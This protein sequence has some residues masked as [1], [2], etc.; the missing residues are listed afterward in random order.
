VAVPTADDYRDYGKQRQHEAR[1][2]LEALKLR[3]DVFKFLGFPDGGLRNLMTKYW[4]ERAA[5]YQSP[6]TRLNRPP[7]SEIIVPNTEFRGEDLTQELAMLIDTFRPT[8]VVVPR[9]EDQHKDHYA[10]TFFVT[11]T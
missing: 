10:D 2:A 3:G 1:G 9:K 11:N 5:S 6:F 4:S 7:H 8:M